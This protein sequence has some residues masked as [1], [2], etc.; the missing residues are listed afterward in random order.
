[1]PASKNSKTQNLPKIYVGDEQ[2]KVAQNKRAQVA[3]LASRTPEK[4]IKQKEGRGGLTLDYVEAN[5]VTARLNATF[6]FDWDVEVLETKILK[7]VG[8]IATQVKLTVR[9]ADGTQVSKTAWGGSEIKK[10]AKGKR[11]GQIIDIADD[12]KGSQSDAMKKA[13]SLLGVCWDVY[14]GATAN[15]RNAKEETEDIVDGE[16]V[17]EDQVEPITEET[18]MEIAEAQMELKGHG[19]KLDGLNERIKKYVKKKFDV[20]VK[21][22]PAG[23][24]EVAGQ[25]VLKNLKAE[26]GKSNPATATEPPGE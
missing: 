18:A 11:Q 10:Y 14:S 4:Y 13:A 17:E 2:V 19:V 24:S 22:I 25:A 9:F 7:E 15:G 3:L 8:Q 23:L 5:Y 1:M 20:D 12:L 6:M 21:D 16:I 26:I